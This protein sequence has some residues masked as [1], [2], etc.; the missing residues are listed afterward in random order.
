MSAKNPLS[1]WQDAA[2][3]LGQNN[4]VLIRV[5]STLFDK[6][7]FG[8]IFLSTLKCSKSS[9]SFS[10]V[11]ISVL[12]HFC[13]TLRPSGTWWF[14]H[15]NN[16]GK[17]MK[18]MKLNVAQFSSTSSFFLPLGPNARLSALFSNGLTLPAIWEIKFHTVTKQGVKL[19][20][21][22]WNFVY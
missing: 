12:P 10:S 15:H 2:T 6:V 1:K 20:L 22:V 19:L 8:V 3:N 17:E 5:Y 4:P 18:I 13:Q 9:I 11:C 7:V 14:R 21:Y 16:T